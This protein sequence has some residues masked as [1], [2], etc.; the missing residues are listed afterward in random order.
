[1]SLTLAINNLPQQEGLHG[2][3]RRVSCWKL[4]EDGI[5]EI[6]A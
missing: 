4:R 1:M 6:M 2:F 3:W 5:G